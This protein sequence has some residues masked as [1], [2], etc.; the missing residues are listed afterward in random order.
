[1]GEKAMKDFIG[2]VLRAGLVFAPGNDCS[3]LRRPGRAAVR[4]STGKAAFTLIELLV[5]I[6]IISLLVSILLPSLN[7]A[8]DLA[9]AVVCSTNERAIGLATIMY[10]NDYDERTPSYWDTTR[11]IEYPELPSMW[12]GA[13]YVYTE[14]IEV[15]RCPMAPHLLEDIENICSWCW[16]GFWRAGVAHGWNDVFLTNRGDLWEWTPDPDKGTVRLSD[17]KSPSATVV[18]SDTDKYCLVE[19]GGTYIQEGGI[20]V[21]ASVRCAGAEGPPGLFPAGL[22]G[23]YSPVF[24]H[25]DKANTLMLDGHV[26]SLDYEALETWELFDLE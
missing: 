12:Y 17:V 9:K 22:T 14:T 24:R 7:R 4:N 20:Q 5:V 25:S 15:F 2:I 18:V 23:W 11:P 16:P 1:M 26:E 6:A 3:S 19:G 13:L 10:C 21:S 8:K